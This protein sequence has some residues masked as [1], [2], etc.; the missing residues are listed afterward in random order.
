LSRNPAAKSPRSEPTSHHFEAAIARLSEIVEALESGDLA[1]EES[2]RLFEEGVRLTRASQA[3]LD[4]A[5][6]RVEELLGID[7]NGNPIV[8]DLRGE[9]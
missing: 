1:L 4:T 9:L 5:E 3:I 2:L 6:K 7:E 8:R